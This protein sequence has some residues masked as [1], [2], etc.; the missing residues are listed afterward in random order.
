MAVG[1]DVEWRRGG[2]GGDRADDCRGVVDVDQVE[3]AVGVGG[4][5]PA[6][7][8]VGQPWESVGTVE[9]GES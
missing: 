3:P 9:A 6:R 5:W 7:L 8:E 1:D 2:C 4:E